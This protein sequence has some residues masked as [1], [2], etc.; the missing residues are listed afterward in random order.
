M[1]VQIT[2]F[3]FIILSI[4]YFVVDEYDI[5][6]LSLFIAYTLIFIENYGM[7]RELKNEM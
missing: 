3:V 2:S 1:I 4:I 6:Y 5:S 7:K